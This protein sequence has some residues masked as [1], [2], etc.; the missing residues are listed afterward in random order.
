M[1][2]AVAA[3][4]DDWALGVR[5]YESMTEAFGFAPDYGATSSLLAVLVAAGRTEE[6]T[7]L[8]ESM[9]EQ[10]LPPRMAEYDQLIRMHCNRMAERI[11]THQRNHTACRADWAHALDVLDMAAA[12]GLQPSPATFSLATASLKDGPTVPKSQRNLVVEC[13]RT[14]WTRLRELGMQPDAKAYDSLISVF[15]RAKDFEQAESAAREARTAGLHSSSWALTALALCAHT[16]TEV[17]AA[18]ALCTGGVS[19]RGDQPLISRAA[20]LHLVRKCAEH[21]LTTQASQL[22]QEAVASGIV[23]AE[24]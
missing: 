8:I 19:H 1:Q 21:R 16:R 24:R 18:V 5:R 20:T 3:A 12:H 17:Q 11:H 4:G 13:T 14:L 9:R 10:G 15:G 7:G 23:T 2:L 22:S 6:A